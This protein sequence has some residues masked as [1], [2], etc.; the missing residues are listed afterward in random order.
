MD[1]QPLLHLPSF[2]SDMDVKDMFGREILP[3]DLNDH[4]MGRALD[5]L[6]EAD[7]E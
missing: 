2:S 1:R 5:K 7:P 4:T 3:A 6:A